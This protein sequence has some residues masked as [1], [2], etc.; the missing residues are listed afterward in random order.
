MMKFYNPLDPSKD[1]QNPFID[2]IRFH[3]RNSEMV[4]EKVY[5]LLKSGV[6]ITGNFTALQILED[7]IEHI[8]HKLDDL[9]IAD[10]HELLDYIRL[11]IL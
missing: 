6:K 9:T 5:R 2:G 3:I 10:E 7:A 11:H 8:G 4:K 1:G